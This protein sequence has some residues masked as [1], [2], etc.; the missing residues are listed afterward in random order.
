VLRMLIDRL[1]VGPV[2]HHGSRTFD[3]DRVHIVWRA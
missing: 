2:I 1:D 3:P